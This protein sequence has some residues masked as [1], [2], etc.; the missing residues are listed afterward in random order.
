MFRLPSSDMIHVFGSINLDLIFSMEALPAPGETLL[1][2]EM[3]VMPGGKGANQ[4]V[5]AALDGARVA[6]HGA[7][8]R[9]GFAADALAG[10][11]R[12]GVDLSGVRAVDAPTGVASVATDRHGRN[13]IAVAPGANLMARQADLADSALRDATLL[14]QMECS[15]TETAGLIERAHGLGAR[16]IL[17]LAPAADL[18]EA[19]LRMVDLLVVNESEA[20][21][22]AA[23]FGCGADAQAVSRRLGVGVVRTL[24]EKGCE[25]AGDGETIAIPARRIEVVDTTAAGDCFVGVLAA[26]LDRGLALGAALRR[27]NVAAGLACTKR[28]SQT[29]LPDAGAIDAA[30]AG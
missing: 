23:Q 11:Q 26:S 14:L 17:N 29:S 19:T 20:A 12:A 16:T 9:D 30:M 10:L 18:L 15:A 27:A 2:R 21:F 7:V 25:A 13:C 28:G 1:A 8:G 4:A 24:G 22:L 3:R 6:M 5:A